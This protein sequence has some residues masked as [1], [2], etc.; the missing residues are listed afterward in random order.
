MSF[1][2]VGGISKRKSEQ[3]DKMPKKLCSNE[4][5][6]SEITLNFFSQNMVH[7]GGDVYTYVNTFK[8]QTRVHIRVFSKDENGSLHPTKNGV[9]LKL[10]VWSDLLR[11]MCHFEPSKDPDAVLTVMKDVCLFNHTVNYRCCVSL[12]RLFQR[13]DLSFQLLPESVVLRDDQF[14]KL[15]DSHELVLESIKHKLLTYTLKEFVLSEMDKHP[16]DGRWNLYDGET[17][18]GV[19]ELTDVLCKQLTDFISSNLLEIVKK[20]CDFLQLCFF[21]AS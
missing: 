11:K 2:K 1:S 8:G 14:N 18:A 16:D 17:P 21:C 6:G 15:R 5:K 12:Q 3:Q 4:R 7:L 9:S 10:L 19:E 20:N 13:K